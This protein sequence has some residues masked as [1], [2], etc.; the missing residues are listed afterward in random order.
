MAQTGTSIADQ[1]VNP[2]ALAGHI[3]EHLPGDGEVQIERLYAGHSNETFFVTR[4]DD[5]WVLRRPPLPPYLPTA[6]DVLREHRVLHALQGTQ[7]RVPRTVL[8]CEDES[9]IGA[10]FYL[11]ERIDGVVI[12]DRLPPEFEDDIPARRQLG[13]ELVDAL[14]ELQSVDYKAVGLENFGRSTGYIERQIKRWSSQ[15]EGATA[16]TRPLPDL[17]R[18][19]EWLTANVPEDQP[20]TIVQGDYKLDNVIFAHGKPARLLAILDWE[21]S[22]I[23]DPLADFGW[24]LSYWRRPRD[25]GSPGFTTT[26]V[27]L[28]EGFPER[29]ELLARYEEK[30]GRSMK[31]FPFYETLAVWKLAI[32]LEGSY[33]RHLAGTTDDPLFAGLKDG[34][35][36]LA[37]RALGTAGLA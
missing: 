2:A 27:T 6:H 36:A 26:G 8:V 20:P 33:A 34:V 22:T 28:S 10:P 21:M 14:A 4:G 24:L 13:I 19:T 1:L 29:E 23:G 18:V 35:P 30:T 16:R 32:L 3:N 9:V 37:Q 12:R 5:R 15:L 25:A 17:E 7:A 31:N 11:M